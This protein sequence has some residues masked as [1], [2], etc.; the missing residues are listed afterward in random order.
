MSMCAAG[1]AIAE[2]LDLG[3]LGVFAIG[4][5]VSWDLHHRSELVRYAV[6]RLPFERSSLVRK[7]TRG[8][9]VHG[10]RLHGDFA[11]IRGARG[12]VTGGFSTKWRCPKSM[13]SRG[14]GRDRDAVIAIGMLSRIAK[15]IRHQT[16]A[17]GSDA[18]DSIR[19]CCLSSAQNSEG[20]LPC[21]EL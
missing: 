8:T 18:S 4:A 7:R 19:A 14:F 16:G 9:Q 12:R 6:G 11:R 15:S 1:R 5:N 21:S 20:I 2:V 3:P 13:P 10:R 17:A